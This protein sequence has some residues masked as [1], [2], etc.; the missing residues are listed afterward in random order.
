[1]SDGAWTKLPAEERLRRALEAARGWDDLR[2]VSTPR[3]WEVMVDVVRRGPVGQEGRR[4]MQFEEHL[5]T[6]LGAPVEVYMEEMKDASKLR[7]GR[8]LQDLERMDDWL[9]RRK[10][11]KKRDGE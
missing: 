11:L 2:V 6:T 9:E 10:D 8:S 5:R 4:L 7:Q 1:M 3:G